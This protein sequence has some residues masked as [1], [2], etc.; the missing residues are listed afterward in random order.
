MLDRISV[1]VDSSSAGER[2]ISVKD[3]RIVFNNSAPLSFH[4]AFDEGDQ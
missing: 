3:G 2:R 1:I 4:S